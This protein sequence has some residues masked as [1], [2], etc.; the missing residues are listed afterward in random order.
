MKKKNKKYQKVLAKKIK[1]NKKSKKALA[2]KIKKN[3]KKSKKKIFHNN[4]FNKI[5]TKV[6]KKK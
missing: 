2:K 6:K 1:K 4:K 5:K 3:K